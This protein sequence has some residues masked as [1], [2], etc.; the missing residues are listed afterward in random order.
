MLFIPIG[1]RGRGELTVGTDCLEEP[2][3]DYPA[4]HRSK[5]AAFPMG[6]KTIRIYDLRTS[7]MWLAYSPFAAGLVS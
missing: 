5:Q 1:Y 7:D 4:K 2:I 3:S 6:M